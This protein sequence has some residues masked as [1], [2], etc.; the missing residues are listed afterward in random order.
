MAIPGRHSATAAI[1]VFL[2]SFPLTSCRYAADGTPGLEYTELS[3]V[4]KKAA[5]SISPVRILARPETWPGG[6]AV[7]FSATPVYLKLEN[8]GDAPLLIRYSD[9]KVLTPTGSKFSALPVCL[10][11]TKVRGPIVPGMPPMLTA[12]AYPPIEEPLFEFRDFRVAPYL[13]SLYPTVPAH[14]GAFPYDLAYNQSQANYWQH[15]DLPNREM[16]MRAVPE[17]VLHPGGWIAGWL[18]FQKFEPMPAGTLVTTL[19]KLSG[20]TLPAIRVPIRTQ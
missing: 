5:T 4:E 13:K 2:I 1:A 8:R 15:T 9:F 7:K 10:I 12:E 17:G 16:I 11:D 14:E 6:E 20:Q 3:P 19:T 18:Y